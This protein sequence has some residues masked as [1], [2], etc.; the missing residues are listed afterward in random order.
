M[1]ET[2]KT[3]IKER[4]TQTMNENSIKKVKEQIRWRKLRNKWSLVCKNGCE[5]KKGELIIFHVQ[6][7]KNKKALWQTCVM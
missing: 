5:V 6:K 4:W 1:A 2:G 7:N 3:W